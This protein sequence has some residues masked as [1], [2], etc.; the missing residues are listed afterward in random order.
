MKG[1]IWN[2]FGLLFARHG[3]T[4]TEKKERHEK[5]HCRQMVEMGVVAALL[6][7]ILIPMLSTGGLWWLLMLAAPFAFYLWYFVEWGYQEVWSWFDGTVDSYKMICLEQEAYANDDDEGYKWR[8]FAWIGYI[9][10]RVIY[11]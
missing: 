10:S 11:D 8:W 9:G 4:V 1:F 6:L 5:I 3:V 2:C 7:G